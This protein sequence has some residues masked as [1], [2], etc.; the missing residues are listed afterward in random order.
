METLIA[1]LQ[2]I[3]V[4]GRMRFNLAFVVFSASAGDNELWVMQKLHRDKVKN[5]QAIYLL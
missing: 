4:L 1:Y 2:S 3:L 5:L